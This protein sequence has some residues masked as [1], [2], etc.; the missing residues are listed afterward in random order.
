MDRTY[1]TRVDEKFPQ[2]LAGERRKEDFTNMPNFM[3][4]EE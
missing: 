1:S 4:I 2:N 3:Y